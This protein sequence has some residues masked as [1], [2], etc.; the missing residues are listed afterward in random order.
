[1]GAIRT[2]DG[3]NLAGADPYPRDHA[4]RFIALG[5]QSARTTTPP[6]AGLLSGFFGDNSKLV[7]F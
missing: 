2:K 7:N 5:A 1:V 6:G 3:A 4:P